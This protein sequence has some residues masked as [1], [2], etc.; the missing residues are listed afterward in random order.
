MN[1]YGIRL[2]RTKQV[3]LFQT[4]Q[5]FLKDDFVVINTIRGKQVG[6]IFYTLK[7]DFKETEVLS[8]ENIIK[9]SQE[10]ISK[11]LESENELDSLL[12]SFKKLALEM[13]PELKLVTNEYTLNKENLI[14][15]FYADTRL[16]FR[17]LVKATNTMFSRKTQFIQIKHSD[18]TKILNVFGRYGKE[19][20]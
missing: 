5:E 8:D 7:N 20:Y 17:A 4:K 11:Y 12:F 2:R 6:N 19:I 1:I 3:F 16:D 10:E 15:Y 18:A 9:L 14:F 13:L